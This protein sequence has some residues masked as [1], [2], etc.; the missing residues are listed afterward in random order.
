MDEKYPISEAPSLKTALSGDYRIILRYF[1]FS[2]LQERP[3]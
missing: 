2:I 1:E 3:K